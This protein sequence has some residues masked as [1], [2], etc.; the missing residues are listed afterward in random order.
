MAGQ[1]GFSAY[2]EAS[3]AYVYYAPTG[4][5]PKLR[6]PSAR[7]RFMDYREAEII[8]PV[9][10]AYPIGIGMTPKGA[11]VSASNVPCMPPCV[12]TTN[13]QAMWSAFMWGLRFLMF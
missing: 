8:M 10:T 4:T 12:D 2:D 11:I 1:F 9:N 3:G 7:G 13:N 6:L 5:N